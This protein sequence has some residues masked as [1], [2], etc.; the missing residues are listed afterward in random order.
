[1]DVGIF[2]GSRAVAQARTTTRDGTELLER[3][4]HTGTLT[5]VQARNTLRHHTTT[6]PPP[7]TAVSRTRRA[8]RPQHLTDPSPPDHQTTRADA[9]MSHIPRQRRPR[10]GARTGTRTGGPAPAAT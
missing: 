7:A 8:S 2:D 10:T 3:A 4:V 1:M 9:P 5:A 6:A